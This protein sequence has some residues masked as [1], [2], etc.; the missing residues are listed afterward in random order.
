MTTKNTKY[1]AAMIVLA[2]VALFALTSLMPAMDSAHAAPAAAIT[3]VAADDP[4]GQTDDPVLIKFYDGTA[5]TAD[6]QQCRDL[7][8]F[9][10][11]DIEYVID[12]GTTNTV[13]VQLEH[14]NGAGATNAVNTDGQVIVSANAADAD[15][16]NRFD[17]F[18]VYTCVDLDVT[19]TN[20]LT[21]TVYGLAR[22]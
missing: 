4:L 13:T 6:G 2:F 18:G 14:T 10:T 15:D 1:L 21:V 8:E 9:R 5:V 3:P 20:T 22:K 16:L 7:S 12:Q 17:L 19:N 11:I